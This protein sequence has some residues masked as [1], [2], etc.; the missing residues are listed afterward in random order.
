METQRWDNSLINVGQAN[1]GTTDVL[2]ESSVQRGEGERQ[3]IQTVER[4]LERHGGT[5]RSGSGAT[6][7]RKNPFCRGTTKKTLGEKWTF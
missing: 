4:K 7:F 5:I 6:Q 2:E 3:K 1:H